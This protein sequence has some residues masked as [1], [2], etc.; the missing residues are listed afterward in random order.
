MILYFTALGM[1]AH[2]AE[3]G[4]AFS[5]RHVVYCRMFRPDPT[6]LVFGSAPP[7][8]L[9]ISKTSE[10]TISDK[11]EMRRKQRHHQRDSFCNR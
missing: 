1:D 6:R 8:S 2:K 10:F 11:P 9:L 4:P 5:A 3:D 7:G